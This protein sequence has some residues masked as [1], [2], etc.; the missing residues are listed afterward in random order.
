MRKPNPAGI[1]PDDQPY[2]ESLYRDLPRVLTEDPDARLDA[3]SILARLRETEGA[4]TAPIG[5]LRRVLI[6]AGYPSERS[7]ILGLRLK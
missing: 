2:L 1:R 3:R 7:V 6:A 5:T 4:D